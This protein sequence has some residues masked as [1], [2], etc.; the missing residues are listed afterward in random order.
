M[1]VDLILID[2][3]IAHQG[4]RRVEIDRALRLFSSGTGQEMM[5]ADLDG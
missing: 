2:G 3:E 4:A 5:M 1:R